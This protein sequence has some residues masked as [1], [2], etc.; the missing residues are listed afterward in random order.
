M[1]FLFYKVDKDQ[2]ELARANF[3]LLKREADAILNVVSIEA[4]LNMFEQLSF[5]CNLIL[6]CMVRS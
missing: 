3:S 1:F 2:A 4:V 6:M 5:Y